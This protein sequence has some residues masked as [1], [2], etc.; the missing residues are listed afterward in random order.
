M[1]DGLV[2][3]QALW[4]QYFVRPRQ[5]QPDPIVNGW[6]NSGELSVLAGNP[7][8]GKSLTVYDL[9]V[10]VSTGSPWLGAVETSRRPVVYLDF[11]NP[12]HYGSELLLRAAK[13]KKVDTLSLLVAIGKEQLTDGFNAARI[14]Q[15]IQMHSVCANFPRPGLLIVDT[16]RSAFGPVFNAIDSEWENRSGLVQQALRGLKTICEETGW[17]VLF[18]HHTNKGGRSP[19]GSNQWTSDPDHHIRLERSNGPAT[20]TYVSGRNLTPPDKP[21]SIAKS[22]AWVSAELSNTQDKN[23]A[24]MEP[25]DRQILKAITRNGRMSERDLRDKAYAS[26]QL[27]LDVVRDSVSRLKSKSLITSCFEARRGNRT[28]V[29]VPV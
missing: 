13:H 4:N 29:F 23:S 19:S 26:R 3:C 24:R 27:R 2:Q 1:T 9:A 17:S 7:N 8:A 12:S 18:I 6:F 11:E 14:V 22:R 5:T 21:L 28:E 16:A 25:V 20:V 15:L 10:S